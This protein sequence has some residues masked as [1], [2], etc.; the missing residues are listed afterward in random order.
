MCDMH[1]PC[2]VQTDRAAKVQKEVEPMHNYELMFI[3]RP[4]VDEETLKTT[5]EKIQS[6]I[7]EHGGEIT[8]VQDMGRRRLAYM[9][10]KFREGIYT[11]YNFKANAA[12]VNEL[13]H[14]LNINDNV[15]RHM[16]INIDE[17]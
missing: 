1:T 16:V 2:S 4:D 7:T 17:K 9:I 8:D 3:V 10:Q 6:V 12:V 14:T 13:N 15:I 11:V 5:R